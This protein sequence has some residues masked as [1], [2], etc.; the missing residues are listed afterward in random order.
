MCKVSAP[1]VMT[2][3][4][5]R[6]RGGGGGQGSSCETVQCKAILIHIVIVSV[7]KNPKTSSTY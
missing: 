3:A 4:I 6:S 5:M 1:R 7:R 2:E